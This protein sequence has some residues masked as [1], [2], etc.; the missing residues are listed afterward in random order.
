MVDR[1]ADGMLD[2]P[3]YAIPDTHPEIVKMIRHCWSHKPS[4]R[5]TLDQITATM[6]KVH[7]RSTCS[8]TENLI[9]RIGKYSQELEDLV[10][11][12]SRELKLE[13]DKVDELL[14]NLLPRYVQ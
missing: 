14:C 1:I 12:R 8:F 7:P 2:I 11:V 9:R 5:P 6:K 10:E 13:T 3:S 4:E